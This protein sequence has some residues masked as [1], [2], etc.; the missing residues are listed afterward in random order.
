MANLRRGS[1]GPEVKELQTALNQQLYPNPHLGV[2]GIFGAKTEAA[3]IAFQKQA[4]I[5][6]DG[7]VGNQTKAALGMSTTGQ[8]YTHRVRLHFRSLTLTD[9]PFNQ[10]L[11]GTQE[12]YAQYNIKVEYGSGESLM[13]TPA[14]AAKFQQI[15]GQCKWDVKS[16]EYAELQKIGSPAP[17]NDI[18]VYFVD[19]FSQSLN[20]CGGHLKNRPACIV[21]KAGTK[22]CVAHE[23]GHVLLTSSFT[24]V[25]IGATSNL[26]YSVDIQRSCPT[27]NPAQ[28]QK[29]KTSPLC[30]SI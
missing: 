18:I 2:D 27:L 15:D 29:I 17:A 3:V 5:L 13:L 9:L 6:V 25:H 24:P 7:I 30:R 8:K 10:I 26:M 4:V 19:R 12:V 21:A 28:V 22:W 14:E 11:A 20:G 1:Q 23:I 16:G